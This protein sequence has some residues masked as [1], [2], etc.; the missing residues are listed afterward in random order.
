MFYGIYQAIHN[1][2]EESPEAVYTRHRHAHWLLVEGLEEM[3]WK[4]LVDKEY[5]PPMLNA[6]AMPEGVDEATLRARLLKEYPTEINSGLGVLNGKI[7][8]S[9]SWDI[10]PGLTTSS[11]Y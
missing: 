1:I 11:S 7:V 9:G 10:T 4:M 3:G 6:V 8:R 2:L 5:R